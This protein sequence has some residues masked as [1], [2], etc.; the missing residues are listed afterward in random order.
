MRNVFLRNKV[1]IIYGL[2]L[3][4]MLLLLQWLQFHFVIMNH[5]FEV[6]IGAIALIFTGLGVWLAVKLTRPKT[7]TI[8]VEKEVYVEQTAPVGIPDEKVLAKSGIS[9]REWEV[10]ALIA[11]GLSN[12][13][14]ADRLFVSLNTVKTHSSNL[15]FKLEVKRRTEAIQK[16]KKLGL[17][18]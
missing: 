8:I 15:F 3:G 7:H 13:Q 9:K 14:I 4:L 18:A 17:L 1:V 16:G 5:S 10:L 12:Q 2:S 6:Y 11:E